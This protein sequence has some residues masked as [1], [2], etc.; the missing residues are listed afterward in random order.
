MSEAERIQ[1][2][3][4]EL[5]QA[6]ESLQQAERRITQLEERSHH[7]EVVDEE[8]HK[9]A[10]EDPLT[11]LPN[12]NIVRQYVEMNLKQVFRYHRAA[13]LLV[14]DLD[15]FRV[16]NDALG[17]GTGDELLRQVA[18]R[19]KTAV[20]DSDILGR[21]GEDEFVI[22]LTQID[23]ELSQEPELKDRQRQQ[24][25]ERARHVA[26]RVAE[27]LAPPF[28]LQGQKVHLFASVGVSLCPGDAETPM[29]LFEHADVALSYAKEQ[30]R[31]RSLVFSPELQELRMQKLL[32][33]NQLRL[34]HTEKQFVLHYQPIVEL[35]SRNVVGVEAL[36]RWQHPQIGMLGPRDFLH[37][38]EET[39]LIIPL[40]DWVLKESTRQLRA[41]GDQGF[42]LFLTVNLS[43]RQLLQAD[44]IP[45][46]LDVLGQNQIEPRHLVVEI[47]ES[48][49]TTMDPE[50]MSR[51]LTDLGEA[52][53]RV[54]IDDFGTGLTSM[55]TLRLEHTRLLKLDR[56]F[57]A[58][59]P[60]ERASMSVCMA[61]IRLAASLNMKSL[62]EG[63]ETERQC[64]YLTKNECD[65][66]QGFFF[67]PPLAAEEI[68]DL[69]RQGKPGAE[70]I[71]IRG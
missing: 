19:L 39:G 5:M 24:L 16:I 68:P 71:G 8:T 6:L 7:A 13:A 4:R 21:K 30:G 64:N 36:L 62:A 63:V 49:A 53:V 60:G 46:L 26:E 61:T 56:T 27:V 28:E 23:E 20:R 67:S 48:A 10:F 43:P 57:V 17:F 3:E 18:E 22:L 9:L 25:G 32:L 44:L 65:L 58:G 31:G 34:A 15:R 66:G 40:G 52:G 55:K 41:W 12:L 70:I 38:L 37:V 11:G 1:Q 69:I 47:A 14:V 42:D 45:M 59:I 29:Q 2:L 50:R 35:S 33:E 51:V 54:A